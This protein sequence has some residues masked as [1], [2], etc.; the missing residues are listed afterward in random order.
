MY[1]KIERYIESEERLMDRPNE[2]GSTELQQES[3]RQQRRGPHDDFMK[4]IVMP[5]RFGVAGKRCSS[6]V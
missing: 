4:A 1:P 5:A 2:T 3:R 6:I